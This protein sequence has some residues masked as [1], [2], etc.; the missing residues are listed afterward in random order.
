MTNKI[1]LKNLPSYVN[2]EEVKGMCDKYGTVQ[3]IEQSAEGDGQF[4]V[5]FESPDQAQQ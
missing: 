1:A 3:K 4:I 2:R 5:T